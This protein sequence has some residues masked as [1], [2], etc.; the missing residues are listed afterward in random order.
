MMM[1]TTVLR[2]EKDVPRVEIDGDRF[3][4]S[5]PHVALGQKF[6][7]RAFIPDLKPF[8]CYDFKDGD[9]IYRQLYGDRVTQPTAYVQ[10]RPMLVPLMRDRDEVDEAFGEENEDGTIMSGGYIRYVPAHAGAVQ[11]VCYGNRAKEPGCI[12]PSIDPNTIALVSCLSEGDILARE[13]MEP[14][15]WVV[16][17]GVLI[18]MNY[19]HT[20]FGFLR[21]AHLVPPSSGYRIRKERQ[22]RWENK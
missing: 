9:Y 13:D 18:C 11:P 2:L 21:D 5:I 10:Y 19:M 3:L 16:Y 4:L 17:D 14:L 6:S 12:A 22:K 1:E 15:K 8:L 20:R 7:T